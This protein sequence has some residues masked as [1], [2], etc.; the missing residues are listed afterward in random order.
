MNEQYFNSR[1]EPRGSTAT[2]V[3]R[4][5]SLCNRDPE[6]VLE[7]IK[8]LLAHGANP[9]ELA[10][11]WNSEISPFLVE[12]KITRKAAICTAIDRVIYKFMERDGQ[13]IGDTARFIRNISDRANNS[14]QSLRRIL[15]DIEK[16]ALAMLA[17]PS[18]WPKDQE[19]SA[20]EK[21]RVL[22]AKNA[23]SSEKVSTYLNTQNS[24]FTR[25]KPAE[26]CDLNLSLDENTA[27]VATREPL[28]TENAIDGCFDG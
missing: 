16:R 18:A 11:R 19:K 27:I 22:E 8:T 21:L 5:L 9:R 13:I 23:K 15:A 25:L 28:P 7:H 2:K 20:H 24:T 4:F 17:E 6:L 3:Q 1:R 10:D 26:N 14:R 12:A